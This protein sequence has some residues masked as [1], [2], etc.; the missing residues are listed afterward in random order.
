MWTKR[1]P[2]ETN[3]PRRLNFQARM[4]TW[5]LLLWLRVMIKVQVNAHMWSAGHT[6]QR[7]CW[8]LFSVFNL[9]TTISAGGSGPSKS[10]TLGKSLAHM[11]SVES[12][13]SDRWQDP[14]NSH[15]NNTELPVSKPTVQV[16]NIYI[17]SCPPQLWTVEPH[18]SSRQSKFAF[19]KLLLS[20][21]T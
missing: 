5:H 14:T 17:S 9:S 20:I 1:R 4:A 8:K 3:Y 13:S 12:D 18:R 11:T 7:H 21:R 6:G 19:S 10:D 16:L 2:R 15:L